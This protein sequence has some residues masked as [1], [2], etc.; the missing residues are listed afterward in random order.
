MNK[1]YKLIL[2]LAL[3]AVS[4]FSSVNLA[5]EPS[6][7][8]LSK[9][10]HSALEFSVRER[11]SKKLTITSVK[12]D[13]K[14]RAYSSLKEGGI[15]AWFMVMFQEDNID[16]TKVTFM[17]SES[18]LSTECDFY[19]REGYENPEILYINLQQCNGAFSESLSGSTEYGLPLIEINK[20]SLSAQK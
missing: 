15:L 20:S 17:T 14:S 7:E 6:Q 1:Q 2:S 16:F 4:S 3:L 8:N 9:Y 10:R 11:V 18:S 5:N 13:E 19:I 12:F